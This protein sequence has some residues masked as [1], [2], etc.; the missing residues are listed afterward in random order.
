M[1]VV[2]GLLAPFHPRRMVSLVLSR[3]SRSARLRR[4]QQEAAADVAEVQQDD[5]YFGPDAP[6]G[7]DEL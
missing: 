2:N 5:K 4:V 1:G 7:E 3:G 6:A